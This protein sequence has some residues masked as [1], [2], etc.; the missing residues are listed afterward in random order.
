MATFHDLTAELVDHLAS[1]FHAPSLCAFR[2]TSR[3]CYERSYHEFEDRVLRL[4]WLVARHSLSA[5]HAM[6]QNQRLASKLKTLRLGTQ[7]IQHEGPSEELEDLLNDSGTETDCLAVTECIDRLE[8][9]LR[10]QDT[11]CHGDDLATLTM[12]LANFPCL[13]AVEIGK[14]FTCTVDESAASYGMQTSCAETGVEYDNF[15][16][17][18]GPD[19]GGGN[20]LTHNLKTMLRALSILRPR[21]KRFSACCWHPESDGDIMGSDMSGVNVAAM[22]ALTGYYAEGLEAAFASLRDLELLLDYSDV[23]RPGG[24]QR[25]LPT[26]LALTPHLQYLRV[27]YTAGSQHRTVLP[28]NPPLL[29][30][31]R[32]FSHDINL[33]NL[34]AFELCNVTITPKDLTDFWQRHSETITTVTLRRVLLMS[35]T[36]HDL[37][38]CVA[39]KGSTFGSLKL[40]WLMDGPDFEGEEAS[41][42]V[43]NED[44]FEECQQCRYNGNDYNMNDCKHISKIISW[45]EY[46]IL[47]DVKR[48]PI[49]DFE[50]AHPLR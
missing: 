3:E 9:Y 21:I 11:F 35:S 48:K 38:R 5:L 20:G 42:N 40:A 27:T 32:L 41:I 7:Y 1:F 46:S 17:P 30:N 26:F 6:S 2:L 23:E 19:K 14:G 29:Q 12:I 10:T 33:P 45:N 47:Q 39:T 50:R 15:C 13:E 25:W 43:F 49:T 37:L 24:R 22:P 16:F 31:P 4:R 8:E 36:W 18:D 34:V 44:G 28:P